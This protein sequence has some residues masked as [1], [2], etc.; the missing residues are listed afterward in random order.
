MRKKSL[1]EISLLLA[2]LLPCLQIF[3]QTTTFNYQGRL[4]L[5]GAPATGNFDIRFTLFDA[6]VN[7]NTVSSPQTFGTVAVAGG[8]FNVTLDYGAA[9]FPGADRWLEIG[10]RPQGSS[11]AYTTLTPRQKI[12]SNP[13]AIQALNATTAA[14]LSGTV[15]AANVT[16]TLSVSQVPALG[17]DKITSG[18]LDVAR[19]PSLDAAKIVTG[20]LAESRIPSLDASKI[21]TGTIDSARLPSLTAVAIPSL[22]ASKITTGTID[23]ARLPA[24]TAANIPV[25]DAS[26]I[27]SGTFSTDRVPDLDAAKITSGNLSISRMPSGIALLNSSPTFTGAVT[28]TGFSG[29]GANLTSLNANNLSSGTVPVAALGNVWK[30]TGNSGTSLGTHFIGTTDP[31]GLDF[32]VGNNRVLRI[33]PAPTSPNFLAGHTGN[34][35]GLGI[36]GSIVAGGGNSGSDRNSVSASF[37]T[38]SGGQGNTIEAGADNSVVVGGYRNLIVTDN[39][40]S[41]IAGGYQNSIQKFS[42]YSAI[43]GGNQNM[44]HTNSNYGTIAGGDRNEIKPGAYRSV[45]SGGV[46]NVIQTN[47]YD[48][49]IVGGNLNEI[50]I[51]S[52]DGII[53]G[54]TDNKI[55][56]VSPESVIAG[57]ASNRVGNQSDSSSVGGGHGNGIGNNSPGSVIAGGEANK[58]EGTSPNSVIGGGKLNAIKVTNDYSTIAG[59]QNNVIDKLGIANFIGGGAT[60]LIAENTYYAVI[61][62]GRSNVIDEASDYAFV[63][64]GQA[65]K[66]GNYSSY[67]GIMTGYDNFVGNDVISGAIVTGEQNR[68]LGEAN[69]SFIGGG[70]SNVIEGEAYDAVISGGEVNE[71]EAGAHHATIPGG[72]ANYAAGPY[73]FAAGVKAKALHYGSFVWGCATDANIESTAN[74]QFT[75]RASGGTRIFSNGTSTLGVTLAPNATSWSTLSDRN[76][77]KDFNEVNPKEIMDK[78]AKVPV[79]SWHYRWEDGTSTPHLGPIAQD[80]K[81]AF[82]P[83]RDDKSISTMEFDGV[84]LAAI[85]G[86][87][88]TVKEKDQELQSLKTQNEDMAK[89]LDALETMI[90]SMGQANTQTGK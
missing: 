69:R 19:I 44:I 32:R 71:V 4:L 5:D 61:A 39:I 11:D 28:A 33:S 22:D 67:S 3:A 35:L 25:L 58:I 60:N 68:V 24:L 7:G 78:L 23:D 55:G 18:T 42:E 84:A 80:F 38:I 47:S 76:S 53:S 1:L 27:T 17:A 43:S 74:N 31:V 88:A 15:S 10:V 77:K 36:S 86:L 89:R 59:G 37:S 65:N 21:T 45:I 50:G 12:T 66:I 87:Y 75:I 54:G 48:S 70:F 26:K 64:S 62:G 30:I 49:V 8:V 40:G 51:G 83:G 14:S 13:Y 72:F 57:G 85:Q 16:G 41:L 52:Y 79:L 56:A 29:S 73:S 20:V 2:L 63:G 82:Y 46:L 6:S 34:Q 9:S 81:A 90:K